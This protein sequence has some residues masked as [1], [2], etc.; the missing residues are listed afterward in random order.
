MENRERDRVE[1]LEESK[2]THEHQK[3]P[4]DKDQVKSSSTDQHFE[5]VDTLKSLLELRRRNEGRL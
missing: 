5:K 4:G 1:R 3:L 2:R